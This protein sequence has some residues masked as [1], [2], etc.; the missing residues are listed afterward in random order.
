MSII[1]G[2]H[3]RKHGAVSRIS[4]RFFDY[5]MEIWE[6][7]VDSSQESIV[8]GQIPKWDIGKRKEEL[9]SFRF[10][11]EISAIDVKR[12]SIDSYF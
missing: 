1:L 12:I 2:D 8:F 9:L 4:A 5:V 11:F 3:F 6:A 10:A 7:G